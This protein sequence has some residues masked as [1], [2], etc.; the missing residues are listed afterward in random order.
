MC[1]YIV[2]TKYLDYDPLKVFDGNRLC[3]I[4]KLNYLAIEELRYFFVLFDKPTIH[5][6]EQR[7]FKKVD[8]RLSSPL[9]YEPKYVDTDGFADWLPTYFVEVRWGG[10]NVLSVGFYHDT[11]CFEYID[12]ISV[13]HEGD[14]L[15]E[16]VKVVLNKIYSGV[17]I[18][19]GDLKGVDM[20]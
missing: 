10:R 6:I 17:G 20:H 1:I 19:H 5:V 2:M 14:E 15:E 4:I 7:I 3:D 18:I 16:V 8:V 9:R 11:L 12:S 13:L